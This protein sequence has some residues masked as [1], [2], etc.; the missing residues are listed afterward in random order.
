MSSF[1]IR[2]CTDTA[3]K[4]QETKTDASPTTTPPIISKMH[5]VVKT[6]TITAI[7]CVTK[8]HNRSTRQ[9]FDTKKLLD[10]CIQ[11]LADSPSYLLDL[12][13]SD[14]ELNDRH[15]PTLSKL[16][17]HPKI[18]TKI[19]S[20]DLSDNR[21][22]IPGAR[23]IASA[24]LSPGKMTALKILNV[25]GNRSL[26]P[27]GCAVL[28][29]L[30]IEANIQKL[31]CSDTALSQ[32]HFD[33]GVKQAANLIQ[34]STALEYLDLSFNDLRPLQFKIIC[35]G[36]L[37]R[38]KTSNLIHLDLSGNPV[39]CLG[40]EMLASS[41][42]ARTVEQSKLRILTLDHCNIKAE[43]MKIL[44]ALIH[45]GYLDEL[46][47]NSNPIGLKGM[48]H[49]ATTLAPCFGKHCS[50]TLPPLPQT[51]ILKAILP[52]DLFACTCCRLR[53]LMMVHNYS[54]PVPNSASLNDE[55]MGKSLI[56]SSLSANNNWVNACLKEL[57]FQV[58][59]P[60]MESTTV[61]GYCPVP[62]QILSTMNSIFLSVIP[63]DCIFFIASFLCT[64]IVRK[65]YGKHTETYGNH[66]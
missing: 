66:F 38:G 19:F 44:A 32:F 1:A 39:G 28:F 55:R 10:K 34:S 36:I 50:V 24:I 9:P 21:F 33:L 3:S 5:N 12:D 2:K 7:D 41:I 56:L 43:G 42:R 45:D 54:T 29:D 64:K 65:T 60:R 47:L 53:T 26:G 27:Y 8:Q 46:Y 58:D 62:M 48:E 23:K 51:H 11:Q 37:N 59:L 20:L 17:T 61:I 40:M 6:S 14:L 35:V 31:F 57:Y 30:A 13:L 18:A 25:S 52:G 16:F 15:T 49:M 22:L 4:Q 63:Q